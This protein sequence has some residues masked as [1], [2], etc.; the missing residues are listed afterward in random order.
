MQYHSVVFASGAFFF[1]LACAQQFTD[2]PLPPSWPGIS[3]ACYD[4]LNTSVSCPGF[5]GTI[6]VNNP[7]LLP[8][9]LTSLCVESCLT[10]LN[11]VR[12]TIIGSCTNSSDVIIYDEIT[13][14]AT[15]IADR[16]IYTYNLVCRVDP[17]SG[18][19]CDTLLIDWLNQDALTTAQNCSDCMLGAAETQLNSP[20]GYDDDF[21][22][23]FELLISNC[24]ATGY[25]YTSP[26]AYTLTAASTS[27]GTGTVTS[28]TATAT[29]C[30]IPYTVQ[31][32]DSC[33]SIA[34]A[35]NVSTFSIINPNGLDSACDNL[36]AGVT[37]CLASP[38]TLYDVQPYDTCNS[39]ILS[40]NPNIT[41]TQFLAWNPNINALC[42]NLYQFQGTYICVSPP[43]GALEN[44]VPTVTL[45]AST[46]TSPV[47]KPTNAFN[48]SNSD[49][50][51]WY[52]IQDGDYC[53]KLS[54]TFGISLQ[55]FYYLNPEVN[56]NCTNLDLGVAYCV[57]AV[58]SIATY[59]GYS[60]SYFFT[61]TA[62]NYSTTT[63]STSTTYPTPYVT[64]ASQLPLASGSATN[65]TEYR[66][67]EPVPAVIDQSQGTDEALFNS[68]VNNCSYLVG[69][70]DLDL[71]T[72]LNLNPTLS[73][74]SCALEP[75]Y[76][77]CLFQGVE[78][79]YPDTIT[80]ECD[81]V[82][83]I[84][85]G[86]ISSCSC[87]INIDGFDANGTY[88]CDGIASDYNITTA[89]I[90]AWNSWAGSDCDTGLYAG[91]SANETNSVC[92]AVN[93]TLT[94]TT[95]SS[96]SATSTSSTLGPTQTGIIS[97]CTEFYTVPSVGSNCQFLD[98]GDSYC[99]AAPSSTTSTTTSSTSTVVS[100]TS[101]TPP[102]PT[103]SGI[104]ADCDAYAV[105][106][107]GDGC[108]TFAT[109]NGIT[110]ADLYLWN[111]VLDNACDNFW[112]DEAYCI[113]ISS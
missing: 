74:V 49:C 95:T 60:T 50:G 51:R 107:A 64:A 43:G 70:Y 7:R 97:T 4:A 31:S 48:E 105:T 19:F 96:T 11:D 55:D 25:S 17:T 58:G 46:V 99:V 47:P 14:P 57:Q 81:D 37:I 98:V 76:S 20:F 9:N 86:T 39:I 78:Q 56:T 69:I 66:N 108:E 30:A 40:Q 3:S 15:Y 113:G 27:S 16:F 6:S 100:T 88:P 12:E 71:D 33:N 52:T 65:C 82:Y 91:L 28:T 93:S 59:T 34:L 54:I 72:F 2:L 1:N 111:P 61:L 36:E 68:F 26:A 67:Y 8:E 35:Y 87:F 103:Q 102:G 73:N 92:V 62:A 53:D 90:L 38:C 110:L 21:A 94:A 104:P 80:T 79:D 32:G 83:T 41:A 44:V 5:L 75:G 84:N 89:E 10:S 77:Y 101:V 45:A 24:S 22:S 29:S 112:L 23:D 13:Y 42:R 63:I 109:R 85:P 18:E 106:E